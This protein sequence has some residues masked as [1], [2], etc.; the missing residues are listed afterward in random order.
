LKV[1]QKASTLQIGTRDLDLL[2][3]TLQEFGIGRERDLLTVHVMV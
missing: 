1:Y 3:L 2:N